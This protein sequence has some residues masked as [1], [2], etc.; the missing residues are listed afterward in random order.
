[1][2][3]LGFAVDTEQRLGAGEPGGEPGIVKE[4]TPAV[5]VIRTYDPEAAQ[6]PQVTG[7]QAGLDCLPRA[8]IEADI[9]SMVVVGPTRENNSSTNCD[10][11]FPVRTMNSRKYRALRMPSLSGICPLKAKPP[12]SSPPIIPST[13]ENL[14][15][16]C[17]KPTGISWTSTPYI[18]ASL[19]EHHGGGDALHDGSPLSLVFQEVIGQEGKDLQGA[20]E[21]AVFVHDIPT[22]SASPSRAMPTA[23]RSSGNLGHQGGEVVGD[24]FRLVHA[25][26]G[27]VAGRRSAQ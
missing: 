12:L 2:R 11:V 14:G 6:F 16:M 22:R 13:W 27:R 23:A 9:P 26:E 25:G 1:M 17:L 5:N 19:F 20:K 8:G 3:T 7:F 4:E 21:G 18:R 15:P 24:G 10:G